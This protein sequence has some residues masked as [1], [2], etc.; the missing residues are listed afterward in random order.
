MAGSS[1]NCTGSGAH[2]K[3]FIQH[4]DTKIEAFNFGIDYTYLETLGIRL[5][6]EGIFLEIIS[7]MQKSR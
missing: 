7:P 6:E 4:E 3:K 1:W 2:G 5:A